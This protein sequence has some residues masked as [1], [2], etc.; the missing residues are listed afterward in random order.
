MNATPMTP[1]SAAASLQASPARK[2]E[3]ATADTP[4]SQVLFEGMALQATSDKGDPQTSRDLA[5]RVEALLERADDAATMSDSSLALLAAA[6]PSRP[7]PAAETLLGLGLSFT[8]PAQAATRAAADTQAD[9]ALDLDTD[10]QRGAPTPAGRGGKPDLAVARA[11]G[12]AAEGEPTQ[13]LFAARLTSED[14]RTAE[15]PGTLI[16]P[17]ALRPAPAPSA[18]DTGAAP[19]VA[20]PRLAPEV[21]TAAWG[22]ALGEKVVWMATGTQQSATLTL[23]PPNLGPLQVV[24]DVSHDQ[25]SANFF[26]AQ[27]EVRQ[28][29]E[30]ALPRLREMMG[31]AGIQLGQA[32]V[33]ADTPSQHSASD[34][35]ATRTSPHEM[36]S[37]EPDQPVA[38]PATRV[39]RGLVDTFA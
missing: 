20:S 38:I 1:S 34:Q 7:I 36:A 12:A 21:G 27:P 8:P 4:F 31:E 19:T 32:N 29:I 26:A 23:N 28:A 10:A 14:A 24:I 18:A 35:H 3:P 25:A 9:A 13:A 5:A 33:S 6:D 17:A 39:G 16:N 37:A 2:G 11:D 15:P 22:Q 30:A